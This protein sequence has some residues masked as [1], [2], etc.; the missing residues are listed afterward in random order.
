MSELQPA[1][2]EF[3][4]LGV[5]VSL[6]A[7]TRGRNAWLERVRAAARDQIAEAERLEEVDLRAAIVWFH[8]DA[9]V[10]DLDNIAKPILDGAAGIAF[11]NDRQIAEVIMRRTPL[12][13]GAIL[14]APPA[15]VAD[16]LGSGQDFVY[17]KLSSEPIDHG[18]LP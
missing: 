17:V 3:V 13:R 14:L 11:G 9:D 5:P 10:A 8:Q 7:R 1:T 4:T 12:D 15:L 6:Q 16:A 18:R 2:V